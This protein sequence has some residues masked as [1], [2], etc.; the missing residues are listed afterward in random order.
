[1]FAGNRECLQGIGNNTVSVDLGR[2]SVHGALSKAD[3][4][5]RGKGFCLTLGFKPAFPPSAVLLWLHFLVL[6][7]LTPSFSF[8]LVKISLA[9]ELCFQ[10]LLLAHSS[11]VGFGR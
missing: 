1:M 4:C 10:R 3:G 5:W 8:L 6:K 11:A 2:T 7:M 9:G